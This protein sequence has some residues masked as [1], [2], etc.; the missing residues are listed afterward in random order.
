MFWS[1][2]NLAR[3]AMK[4]CPEPWAFKAVAEISLQ[5]R[6]DKESRQQWYRTEST[7]H[8]FY[9]P[10]E[11]ENPNLRCSKE[12]PPRALHGIVADFDM[13]ISPERV[14][15]AVRD[16]KVKPA[17]IERSLGGNVRLVWTFSRPLPI[18]G[19]DFA[20]AVLEASVKWLGMGL[21]PGLD[22]A[23]LINP[24]RL[25]CNGCEWQAT[26]APPVNEIEL[27]NFFFK[28][29]KD[30]AYKGNAA[31]ADVPLD[32][33]EVKLRE[34]Y[35]TFMWPSDFLP[36]TQGP[37]FWIPGSTS[38]M[39]AIVKS[40]GM[41]TFAAHATKSFYTW[42][43]LLG[44][45]FAKT[46]LQ[47]A[48]YK[49]TNDVW[50]DFRQFWIKRMLND[51]VCYTPTQ[52]EEMNR[53]L[54][55]DC[56]L[57]DKAASP[58][59]P[60]QLQQAIHHIQN[61]NWIHSAAPF[62]GRGPG[63]F[64]FQ[65][66]KI[67]N[68]YVSNLVKPADG[69]VTWESIPFIAHLIDNMF[70]SPIQKDHFLAWLKHFY[71]GFLNEKPQPGQ[72]ICLLGHVAK[73]KTLLN[74]EVVG[75]LIGR[76]A[77]GSAY[78]VQGSPFN[79]E[80]FEAGLWCV[81]D[82]SA[83]NSLQSQNFFEIML[84]KSVANDTARFN[85]KYEAAAIVQWLG[86]IFCTANLDHV[87]I[88]LIGSLDSSSA[89]KIHLFKCSSTPT[90]F[91]SREIVS[92]SINEELPRLARWLVDWTVP[93]HITPDPRFGFKA[94][95]EPELLSQVKQTSSNANFRELLTESLADWFKERPEATEYRGTQIQI[96]RLLSWNPLNA[97]IIRQLRIEK[98]SRYLQDYSR[99]G[100]V[101][102]TMVPGPSLTT[103]YIFQRKDIINE[104]P[105]NT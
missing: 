52:S 75:R 97:E 31:T 36:D 92:N 82:E 42:T 99:T 54:K 62:A 74:R 85:K 63:S 14:S 44:A 79:S 3:L 5:V 16:M 22:E 103:I 45:D 21:L 26:G 49:A 73:G 47:T 98:I 100:T 84:K 56:K 37:S 83:G 35:P 96:H 104:P 24:T 1:L 53:I 2:E 95:Q 93:D 77:D 15:E 13:P 4:P 41:L 27:Q 94:Y 46:Y 65:G 76:I 101:P 18:E 69:K 78:L 105:T 89:D 88:R 19:T 48:L 12:N 68:T 72:A 28:C 7:S 51:K 11:P 25:Y 40:G 9:T 33:V 38:P 39:S 70:S 20:T 60:S 80:L 8:N 86:R 34:M 30:F 81:D 71:I 43:D 102:C 23:A 50:W 66:K 64:V 17:W 55:V 87:S 61:Q 91:P 6:K 10:I 58:G 32:V 90:I 67:L 29:A 59:E 57:N